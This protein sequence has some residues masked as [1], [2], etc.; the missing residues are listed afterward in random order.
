MLADPTFGTF[1][2][3][4]AFDDF[5][6]IALHGTFLIDGDGLLRWSDVGFE[7]F[8]DAAFLLAES[9]RLLTRPVAPVPGAKVIAA[10]RAAVPNRR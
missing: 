1:Q 3:Y 5:E 10:D 2:A 9:K 8:T 7:P 4:G 6:Q